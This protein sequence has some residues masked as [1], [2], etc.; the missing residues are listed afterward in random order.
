[1]LQIGKRR[2]DNSWLTARSC[3]MGE[4]KGEEDGADSTPI[5]NTE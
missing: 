3:G 2:V 5:Q 4:K 1:M